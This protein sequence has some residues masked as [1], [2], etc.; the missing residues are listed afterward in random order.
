MSMH[1]IYTLACSGEFNQVFKP[2]LR[3]FGQNPGT[4]LSYFIG[5]M[6]FYY[7]NDKLIDDTWFYR[8]RRDIEID[9]ALSNGQQRTAIKKLI[10]LRIVEAEKKDNPAKMYYKINTSILTFFLNEYNILEKCLKNNTPDKLTEFS[11]KALQEYRSTKTLPQEVMKPNI[12]MYENLTTILYTYI[13]NYK[14]IEKIPFIEKLSLETTLLKEALENSF[15]EEPKK[16]KYPK[17]LISFQDSIKY[18]PEDYQ[19][20]KD[21]KKAW[22]RWLIYRQKILKNPVALSMVKRHAKELPEFFDLQDAIDRIGDAIDSK[23]WRGLVFKED[24]NPVKQKGGNGGNG[25]QPEPIKEAK[26]IIDAF[27][28]E[29]PNIKRLNTAV[30]ETEAYLDKWTNKWYEQRKGTEAMDNHYW[31]MATIIPGVKE[32]YEKY[33]ESLS[34]VNGQPNEA[35]FDFGNTQFIKFRKQYQKN[36]SGVNWETGSNL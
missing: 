8:K 31:S 35:L 5:K 27:E 6:N 21:F 22:R 11:R 24:K 1:P 4:I 3:L 33:I 14:N 19:K 10:D 29:S 13:N 34:W 30:Q 16:E 25:K 23:K 2:C 12:K 28:M 32:V 17:E 20:N 9:T 18:F 26:M 15:Q 36:I 7:T